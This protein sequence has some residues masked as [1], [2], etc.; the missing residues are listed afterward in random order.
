MMRK[1]ERG[2]YTATH[3][4]CGK[5]LEING[6]NRAVLM[7]QDLHGGEEPAGER[8]LSVALFALN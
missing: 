5:A 2:R 1:L 4:R 6:N 3:L 8:E 7:G